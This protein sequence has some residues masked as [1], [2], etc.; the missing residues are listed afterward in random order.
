MDSV[1]WI[2]NRT[3]E[4]FGQILV[5]NPSSQDIE[6]EKFD[7]DFSFYI[8]SEESYD[9]ICE[10]AKTVSEIENII[11]KALPADLEVLFLWVE[12]NVHQYVEVMH[13]IWEITQ[14]F[15]LFIF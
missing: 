12:L 14:F 11:K 13:F 3:A 5:Y 7:Y 4:G 2:G 15:V 9:K 8:A 6:D 10:A 1:I